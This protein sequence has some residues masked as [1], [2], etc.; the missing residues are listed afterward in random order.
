M[1]AGGAAQ[2][3]HHKR[4]RR[5]IIK[6]SFG[7]GSG[8]GGD[9]LTFVGGLMKGALVSD[10]EYRLRW[11][12]CEC[13]LLCVPLCQIDHRYGKCKLI[14]PMASCMARLRALAISEKERE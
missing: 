1:A 10:E 14:G 7:G 12:V 11:Y 4:C 8:D 5:S 2:E 3:A 13:V 6:F 9:S